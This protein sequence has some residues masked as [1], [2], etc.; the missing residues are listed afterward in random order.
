[1]EA[2]IWRARLQEGKQ[3]S[4]E[5]SDKL[6]EFS[7]SKDATALQYCQTLRQ[8]GNWQNVPGHTETSVFTSTAVDACKKALANV[9]L[10]ELEKNWL[11][12]HLGFKAAKKTQ[13]RGLQESPCLRD[14]FCHCKDRKGRI[15]K[16]MWDC[17]CRKLKDTFA[18][19]NQQQLLK[20]AS[21]AVLF[22]G[23]STEPMPVYAVRIAFVA[24]Q[25][26]R[27]WTP[28]FVELDFQSST[29]QERV[30]HILGI[31][32]GPQTEVANDMYITTHIKG[33]ATNGPH[34]STPHALMD[35]FDEQ[36]C[37]SLATA[38]LSERGV[39]FFH[40][41]G[42]LQLHISA[43]KPIQF[44]DPALQALPLGEK[45]HKK[46][47]TTASGMGHGHGE[48]SSVV[49]LADDDLEG[50]GE[51]GD[52]AS[53]ASQESEK[54]DNEMDISDELWRVWEEVAI[55]K[56]V[57]ESS[58]SDS[59]STST[60][61][62][63]STRKAKHKDEKRQKAA[64]KAQAKGATRDATHVTEY[65]PH[66]LVERYTRG[67]CTGYQLTCRHPAHDRCS[68]ELAASVTGSLASTRRILKAWAIMGKSMA[69][70]QEHMHRAHR[71][72]LLSALR[73]GSLLTE[74]R[75]DALADATADSD[76]TTVTT[77]V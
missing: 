41:N 75:L 30:L 66:H 36:W 63:S 72:T 10:V 65:G 54:E 6:H 61:S 68:K 15:V 44:W 73:N 22:V 64:P 71:A 38:T 2:K 14:Y 67:V 70:R 53:D 4:S 45:P 7:K 1:M 35:S 69:D 31:F 9:N 48:Q 49:G 58:S 42:L 60:T 50:V 57:A 27:P 55:D 16:K 21:V 18:E 74:A 62:S 52:E 32:S 20:D 5:T 29:D 56:E 3:Q 23:A 37:W 77:Q 34:F 43:L 12:R 25:Y 26:L 51:L 46:R 33:N 76:I 19:P 11:N 39:P 8:L 28:T 13:I 47:K 24:L 40:S 59:S 17:A